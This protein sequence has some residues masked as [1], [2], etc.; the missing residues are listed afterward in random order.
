MFKKSLLFLL[1]IIFAANLSAQ[2]RDSKKRSKWRDRWED[3]WDMWDNEARPFLE[4][5][6]GL[7]EPKHKNLNDSL[8]KVG[9]LEFKIGYSTL[10][11][12]E[13]DY[14]LELDDKYIFGSNISND[15]KDSEKKLTG[16]NTDA[17]RFG[18]GNRTGFGYK[19]GE[20]SILPYYQ[21]DFTW[22]KLDVKNLPDPSL[23]QTIV[24]FVEQ[25]VNTLKRYDGAFRFGTSNTGGLKI[26]VAGL[27]GLSADYETAVIYP[28]HL[29]W[30]QGG[31]F[32]AEQFIIQAVDYFIEE[33]M[34]RS[35]AAAPIVNFVLK[36]GVSYAFYALRRND[37]NWPFKTETP[38][39][40]ETAR[41]G[42][43]FAL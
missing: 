11:I 9:M 39:T 15:L 8:N 36:N 12:Y 16:Y 13:R 10:D 1:L 6:Y 14:I 29:V 26:E 43:S 23:L 24:P 38:L 37:M 31:S 20:V 34:D 7:G 32:L 25:D 21:Y 35:P 19:L 18:F 4:F 2:D 3:R 33:I 40:Y 42:L 41:F 27:L 5:N 17:W 28:R 22:T 30:K